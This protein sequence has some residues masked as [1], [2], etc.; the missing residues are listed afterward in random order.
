MVLARS[1]CALFAYLDDSSGGFEIR[2][3]RMCEV[4]IS[5][6]V[7]GAAAACFQFAFVAEARGVVD[8]E[9][10]EVPVRNADPVRCRRA[11]RAY[12]SEMRVA[13][14]YVSQTLISPIMP[15]KKFAGVAV[16]ASAPMNTL[17]RSTSVVGPPFQTSPW[18]AAQRHRDRS[19]TPLAFTRNGDVMPLPSQAVEFAVP[20]IRSQLAPAVSGRSTH[21]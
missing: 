6:P 3:R 18:R 8:A 17:R 7:T 15:A 4:E 9:R 12:G 11:C 21:V 10:V 5:E 2:I 14:R 1:P 16:V 19:S 13:V 20:V